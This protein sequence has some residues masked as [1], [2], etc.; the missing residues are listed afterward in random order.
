MQVLSPAPRDLWAAAIAADPLATAD[1]T[2]AWTDAV[3][4]QGWRDA[5]RAYLLDDGRSLVLPLVR[6]AGWQASMPP[7]W[8]FG[9]LVGD[10]AHDPEVVRQVLADLRTARAVTTRVRP[11]PQDGAAWGRGIAR[12]AHVLDL[13]PG[14]DALLAAMRKSTRRAVRQEHDVVLG[15]LD[16][17]ELLWHASVERWSTRQG[18]PLWL[19]RRRAV[20]RDPPRRMRVLADHLGDAFRVWVARIDGR[21]VAANVAVFGRAAHAT[22][23]VSDTTRAP[24]G[25]MQ[26]LDWLAI[27]EASARGCSVMH[28]G[29]SGQSSSLAFYK[30]GLGAVPH[31]YAEVR[32]ERLPLTAADRAA[33]TAVKRLIGFRG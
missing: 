19:G 4:T 22:R 29:E 16:A 33:R 14:P 2:P 27:Q 26:H 28:L 31:D 12:R 15:D 9:G 18:E 10:G 25:V 1:G 8:G 7:G 23:A 32:I 11:L 6:R 21:P 5:S 20:L 3:T 30:E 17:Y 13:A 24:S